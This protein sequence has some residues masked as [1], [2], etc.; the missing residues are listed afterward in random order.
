MY[1]AIIPENIPVGTFVMRVSAVDADESGT[2]NAR[3]DYSLRGPHS[4]M[5]VMHRK[6]GNIWYTTLTQDGE[7]V[8]YI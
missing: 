8:A 4:N 1:E 3:I 2:P 6:S 5:F 7:N